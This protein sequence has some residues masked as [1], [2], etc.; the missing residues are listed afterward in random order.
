MERWESPETVIVHFYGHTD[1]PP[2]VCFDLPLPSKFQWD[3]D[4]VGA[5]F[6]RTG[7]EVF[8]G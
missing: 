5:A 8:E 7:L 3:N 4:K 1:E 2:V 6:V